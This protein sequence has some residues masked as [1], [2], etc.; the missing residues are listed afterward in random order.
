MLEI[1]FSQIL[2]M[3]LTAGVCI[4]VVSMLHL[5][6]HRIPRKYLYALWIV[7]AFRLV[8]PVSVSTPVGLVLMG[9]VGQIEQTSVTDELVQSENEET[10]AEDVQWSTDD[11]QK[12]V[13]SQGAGNVQGESE[14]TT[15]QNAMTDTTAMQDSSADIHD[16]T[17]GTA[18]ST[19][20]N[21]STDNTANDQ[22]MLPLFS[23]Y[24]AYGHAPFSHLL[25]IQL[26]E[27]KTQIKPCSAGRG[28]D[29]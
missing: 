18:Q 26:S 9:N 5:V 23:P 21:V 20:S 2:K 3:S 24:L 10:A 16:N 4:V 11:V 14:G 13:D 1:I 28:Y 22:S 29:Q 25:A 15:A 17:T 12:A 6:F 19:A 27:N 8:C 7:V